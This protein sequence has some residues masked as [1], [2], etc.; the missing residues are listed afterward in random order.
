MYYA[1]NKM[2]KNN[3]C[4]ICNNK[5][6]VTYEHIY[7]KLFKEDCRE[8]SIN[9]INGSFYCYCINANNNFYY[10]NKIAKCNL[11]DIKV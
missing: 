9:D 8:C 10:K 11:C 4:N 5:L 3:T 2:N 7:V 6:C 1:N